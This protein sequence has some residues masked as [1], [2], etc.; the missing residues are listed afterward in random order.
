M[1]LCILEYFV[2][3]AVPQP[4][5]KVEVS[6]HRTEEGAFWA[7]KHLNGGTDYDKGPRDLH[8]SRW[9]SSTEY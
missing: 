3:V 6:A 5:K 7:D 1:I 4:K 9:A 8:A 2:P